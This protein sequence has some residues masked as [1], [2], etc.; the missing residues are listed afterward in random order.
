MNRPVYIAECGL[1]CA[2]GDSPAAAAAALLA[3]ESASS[4]RALGCRR[5][6]WF[7]LP[8]IETDWLTRAE[9]AVRQLGAALAPLDSATPLFVAS[10]SFD[11]GSLETRSPCELHV[12]NAAFSRQ[13]AAWLGLDGLRASF[14]NAC[15]SGFSAIEAAHSLIAAGQIDEAIVLGLELANVSTLAGFAALELLSPDLCRPFDRKR[16]GLVLGEAVAA[17]R[18]CAAPTPWRIAAIRTGLDAFSLTGPDPS[19]EPIAALL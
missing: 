9:H 16:N 14:S 19:G 5:F 1:V 12:A 3:G 15:I 18:L 11:L 7:A 10:S 2:R 8:L 13:L 17:A 4:S 6:P